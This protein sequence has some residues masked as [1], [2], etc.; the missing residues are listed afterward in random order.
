MLQLQVFNVHLD[1][2]RSRKFPITV[3][4]HNL[5]PILNITDV[6]GLAEKVSKAVQ[7]CYT[8]LELL[9]A[10]GQS[11]GR[12]KSPSSCEPRE[13]LSLTRRPAT[14]TIAAAARHLPDS[15]T[16]RQAADR[17]LDGLGFS[18]VPNP[19]SWAAVRLMYVRAAA[20]PSSL[21]FSTPGK[22]GWLLVLQQSVKGSRGM[23]VAALYGCVTTLEAAAIEYGGTAWVQRP[24]SAGAAATSVATWLGMLKLS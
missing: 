9:K 16:A 5:R 21:T 22:P 12:A 19:L 20:D 18:N 10:K 7:L 8:R 2:G 4:L 11:P 17:Q 13:R 6:E 14:H 15:V 23:S 3:P 1:V 24:G